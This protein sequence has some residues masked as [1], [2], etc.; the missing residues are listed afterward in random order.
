MKTNLIIKLNLIGLFFSLTIFENLGFGKDEISEL[1]P[2]SRGILNK[3]SI[4]NGF[5]FNENNAITIPS[6]TLGKLL[7]SAGHEAGNQNEWTSDGGGGEYNSGTGNSA[8]STTFARTG[9]YSL[10]LS[11]NTTSGDSHGTRN[12][13]WKEIGNNMDIIFTQYFYFP[14]KIDLNPNNAW[15]NL[16]QT[17]GVK[18]AP[19]GAGT[20]RDQINNPHFIVGI[21]V[22]GGAGSG[23]ANYLTLADLQKFWGGTTNV[24]WKA[25]VGINLPVNKWV[26][27]QMRIIQDRGNNGRVLLWQDDV[28]VVDTGLRNTL[29][30]EVD[31]NQFSLNAYADKTIPNTTSYFTD[32]LSINLPGE[33]SSQPFKVTT[34]PSPTAG[35]KILLSQFTKDTKVE[36]T[37]PLNNTIALKNSTILIRST[38]TSTASEVQKIEYFRDGV[39]LGSSLNFPYEFNWLNVGE[40]VYQI[41]VKAYFKNG[42]TKYSLINNIL[43]K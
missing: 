38:A 18:F 7:W 42:D 14:A 26:K 40:G 8:V 17:K 20:G 43:V 31:V 32:D 35:G 1:K 25:P 5:V 10:K 13:R 37:S 28:L 19:G 23:G 16:L 39:L 29:R 15:F 2:F 3:E 30:P 22:R 34:S 9:I 11:I 12:F 6:N 36:I 24:V 41:Q 27:I 4:N 33:T 21:D